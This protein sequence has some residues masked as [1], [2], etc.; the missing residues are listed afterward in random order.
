MA[1]YNHNPFGAFAEGL[2]G[3]VRQLGEVPMSTLKMG[4]LQ[5]ELIQADFQAKQL[6]RMDNANTQIQALVNQMQNDPKYQPET[7]NVDMDTGQTVKVKNPNQ[8]NISVDID[9]QIPSIMRQNGLIKEAQEYEAKNFEKALKFSELGTQL[10]KSPLIKIDPS[11]R[12]MALT[13]HAQG[14]K[15][16]APHLGIDPSTVDGYLEKAKSMPVDDEP[17]QKFIKTLG[18]IQGQ[19][20]GGKL[21]NE[22]AK[23]AT[24]NALAQ[25]APYLDKEHLGLATDYM[26]SLDAVRNRS[27]E[28]II[29]GAAAGN[30]QDQATLDLYKKTKVNIANGGMEFGGNPVNGDPLA[31][32]DPGTANIVRNIAA[33][34]MPLPSGFALKTPYWQNILGRVSLLDPDFDASQYNTKLAL[35]KGFTSGKQSQNILGLNTAVG[36]INSLVNAFAALNN[37]SYESANQAE[38]LMAKYLPIT[39]GLKKRQGDITSA[40]AKFNAVKGE[41]AAIFKQSG[42]TDQEIKS[43][44]DTITSKNVASSTPDQQKAFVNSTLEL[45]GSRLGALNSQYEM[46]MGKPKDFRMLSDKSREIL[47]KL[48]VDVDKLDPV[49][50]Q[51][52]P[53]VPTGGNGGGQYSDL[54]SKYFPGEEKQAS[55]VMKAESNFNPGAINTKNGNKTTDW[56]LMQI[57]DVNVPRLI[58][59]GVITKAEDLLDPETNVMA[60][61][62]LRGQDGWQPWDASKKNWGPKV[63]AKAEPS[64]KAQPAPTKEYKPVAVNGGG[65]LRRVK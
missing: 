21:R 34:K 31:G 61:A 59:A 51:Q 62:W 40:D 54:I 50:E 14:L 38:N 23:T 58:K 44:N 1:G 48:G 8:L 20:A 22:D 47:G 10:G 4:L 12:N 55:A 19:V 5:K 33:Y 16:L 35:R 15:L 36:H 43:W 53:Q 25:Y 29:A 60:A 45:M 64:P 39:P 24:M 46:G 42:A 57:N 65:T 30:A 6:Q 32:L 7:E 11:L 9:R 17:T 41:L 3:G 63:V 37:S 26:K 56:G 52:T 27:L 2:A 13:Y 28:N 18:L 49:V